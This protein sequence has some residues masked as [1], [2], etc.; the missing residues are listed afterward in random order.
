MKGHFPVSS[1]FDSVLLL[2]FL[3]LF[4]KVKKVIFLKKNLYVGE[5]SH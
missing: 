5:G 3:Y 4:K 2:I 1:R